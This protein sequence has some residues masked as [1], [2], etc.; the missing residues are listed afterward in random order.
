MK[1]K[2]QYST[3]H[4]S[5]ID[6]YG[7]VLCLDFVNTVQ[8]RTKEP[9]VNYLNTPEDWI[10]WLIRVGLVRLPV[11]LNIEKIQIQLLTKNRETI[12]RLITSIVSSREISSSLWADVNAEIQKAFGKVILTNTK[13]KILPRWTFDETNPMNYQYPIFKSL[14]DL[15]LSENLSRIKSCGG[16]G[17]LFLD[18][19]KNSSRRW[20]DMRFCGSQDK[21]KRY[22]HRKTK[23]KQGQ[24]IK[25]S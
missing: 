9:M 4:L 14:Y 7:G 13:G 18:T 10:A 25:K 12:F 24:I 5:K 23:K 15:L 22:Y 11:E 17:W 1:I 16:C 19:S 3:S 20:C 2:H 8:D 6:L 21:S